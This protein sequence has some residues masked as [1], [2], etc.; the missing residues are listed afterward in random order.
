M[1]TWVTTTIAP[2]QLALSLICFC[3]DRLINSEENICHLRSNLCRFASYRIWIELLVSN[4]RTPARPEVNL[5]LCFVLVFVFFGEHRARY[6]ISTETK[7]KQQSRGEETLCNMI[8]IQRAASTS[9]HRR[10][11]RKMCFEFTHLFFSFEPSA[12]RAFL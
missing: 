5:W 1:L 9:W 6:H 11:R 7:P 4:V 2:L 3:C 12:A 8:S 10:T